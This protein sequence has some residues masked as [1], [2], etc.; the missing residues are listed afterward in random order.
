MDDLALANNP[1]SPYRTGRI[2]RMDHFI[3]T[4]R[5]GGNPTAE[6][7]GPDSRRRT[8]PDRLGMRPA[9][10]HPADLASRQPGLGRISSY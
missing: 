2:T 10:Y 3:G 6:L 7:T 8:F 1:L 9:R 4:F 5:F